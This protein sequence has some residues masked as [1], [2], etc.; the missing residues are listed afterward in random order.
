MHSNICVEFNLKKERSKMTNVFKFETADVFIAAQIINLFSTVA[1]AVID[2]SPVAAKQTTKSQL[3]KTEV[4]A[5][6]S[7]ASEAAV[8]E[9][10]GAEFVGVEAPAQAVDVTDGELVAAANAALIKLGGASAAS[11]LKDWV[12]SNFQREDGTP[13]T[14]MLTKKSSRRELLSKLKLIEAGELG[15][16]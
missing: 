3:K 8:S 12:A 4:A 7:A 9:D 6:A 5:P 10:T 2:P 11:R 16:E 13:G 1:G 15:V 14:L